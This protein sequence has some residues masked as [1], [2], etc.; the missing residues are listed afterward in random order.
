MSYRTFKRLLGEASLERKC[1]FLFGGGL[2]LLITG[3]FYF[4]GRLTSKLVYDQNRMTG[5]QLVAP[6]IL[7]KHWRW[8]EA[9]R[10]FSAVIGSLSQDPKPSAVQDYSWDLLHLSP[11]DP[12][13]RPGDQLDYEILH[14]MEQGKTDETYRI[15]R[16]ERGEYHYYWAVKAKESCLQCHV[17]SDR[18]PSENA[19]SIQLLDPH[20]IKITSRGLALNEDSED[21]TLLKKQVQ[22][23]GTIQSLLVGERNGKYE[24]IAGEPRLLAALSIGFDKVPCKVFDLNDPNLKVG[25]FL[26]MVKVVF[27]LSNTERALAWNNAVLLA[28]GIGTVFLAMIGAY[29][30]VRYVIVKPLMHLKDVS[31]AISRGNLD[32]RA[33]IRT[34]DEYEELSQAF[35]R[36]L[37]H[38]VAAQEELKQVN[39]QLDGKVDQL[40]QAN[41]QLFELNNLKNDFLATLTHELRTPLNSILGFSDVLAG[42]ETLS[43]K[44][45]RYVKNIQ[46]SGKDLLTLVND[47]LDL[48]KIEAGKMDLHI[49]DF[50]LQD[51]IERLANMLK[52]LAEKRNIEMTAEC[53]PMLPVLTQDSGK[54][55]QVLYNLVS[56]AIKFTPEGGRV[57]IIARRV[58]RVPSNGHTD[59]LCDMVEILVEDTGVGIPLED[60]DSIFEKFR[61]GNTLRGERRTTL[62]REFAGTGLGLSIVKE[63]CKLLGGEVSLFSEVGKG[64]TFTVRVPLVLRE[65]PRRLSESLSSTIDMA[66]LKRIH[67]GAANK[68][69]QP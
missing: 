68:T 39:S 62:T 60:Q 47:I 46:S 15:V 55:Q 7:E 33:D 54:L 14:E 6:I 23:A 57:Q 32:Q 27:P 18:S 37:R 2:M 1:R 29:A 58:S 30:I 51:L 48:A 17:R 9:D 67:L 65:Q 8:F 5:Q 38:L 53:D 24:L 3:S 13:K 36:M 10:E 22:A 66:E 26:G 25:D 20:D 56:N 11:A 16:N 12:K 59:S 45:Q 42:V 40:A 28:T 44:Q 31:D 34:G 63:L 21:F 43:D 49:T 4:Y 19:D 69:V 41:M 64:S 50:V 52:P 61:Q 35:N